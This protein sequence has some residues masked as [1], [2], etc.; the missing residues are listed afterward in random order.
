LPF[1][2]L[3]LPFSLSFPSNLSN[4]FVH[5]LVW[6]ERASRK[7]K[8]GFLWRLLCQSSRIVFGWLFG[9]LIIFFS[10][11][12]NEKN[13][14]L[15]DKWLPRNHLTSHLTTL[16]ILSTFAKELYNIEYVTYNVQ[17]SMTNFG[18]FFSKRFIIF[19]I[20]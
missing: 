20:L 13:I 2:C 17:S 10:F 3:T 8:V 11:Y 14:G 16:V 1:T 5:V 7:S 9:K 15:R 18:L 4:N 19:F 6:F 12:N